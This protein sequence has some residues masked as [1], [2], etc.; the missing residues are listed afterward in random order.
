MEIE[1]GTTKKKLTKAMIKQFAHATL[2]DMQSIEGSGFYVRDL[3]ASYAKKVAVF[4]T[5]NGWRRMNLRYGNSMKYRSKRIRDE[6]FA[7]YKVVKYRCN[8]HVI[9]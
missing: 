9:I 2:S 4:R 6:F 7:A 3:G 8:R 1:I 5:A